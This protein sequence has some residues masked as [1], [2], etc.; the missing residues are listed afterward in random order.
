MQENNSK[1]EEQFKASTLPTCS[2]HTSSS[3]GMTC[4]MITKCIPLHPYTIPDLLTIGDLNTVTNSTWDARSKW[5]EVGLAL[6]I[7]ATTLDA[8]RVNKQSCEDCYTEMLKQWL[9]GDYPMQTWNGLASAL[10]SP[11]VGMDALANQLPPKRIS[12]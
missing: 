9:E 5:C 11:S 6:G 8:I 1:R 10:K 7:L 2:T 12:S 4:P 3:T